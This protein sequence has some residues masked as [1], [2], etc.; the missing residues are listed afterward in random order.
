MVD[1]FDYG[2]M[3]DSGRGLPSFHGRL[4]AHLGQ[5]QLTLTLSEADMT[6]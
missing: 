5:L 3:L 1:R 2:V 4:C 6:K